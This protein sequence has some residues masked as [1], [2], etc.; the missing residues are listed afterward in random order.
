MR[1]ERQACTCLQGGPAE[2][3][4][5]HH[6]SNDADASAPS[7]ALPPFNHCAFPI[8]FLRASH[9]TDSRPRD[10]AHTHRI[11]CVTGQT[12]TCKEPLLQDCLATL[13]VFHSSAS[14]IEIRISQNGALSTRAAATIQEALNPAVL[15][16]V[17]ALRLRVWLPST[18][19]TQNRH[20]LPQPRHHHSLPGNEETDANSDMA[21]M[22]RI[23][24]A[25]T[26]VPAVRACA[27]GD[28]AS[29]TMSA[30]AA[31]TAPAATTALAAQAHTR[32]VAALKPCRRWA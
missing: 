20:F 3:K 10:S 5:G 25:A 9:H 17:A 31:T 15:T 22:T 8:I 2:T 12:P 32:L 29:T 19:R 16:C 7:Q 13:T 14:W 18:G 4:R 1:G 21:P 11:H 6:K 28:M 30:S 24:T 23:A 27:D 26:T